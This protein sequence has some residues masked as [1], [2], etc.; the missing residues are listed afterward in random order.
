MSLKVVG[1]RPLTPHVE[2]HLIETGLCLTRPATRGALDNAALERGFDQ[3]TSPVGT[4]WV[5]GSCDNAPEPDDEAWTSFI[6]ALD[7]GPPFRVETA[8]CLRAPSGTLY[9]FELTTWTR[10]LGSAQ[11]GDGQFSYLRDGDV[12]GCE[13]GFHGANCESSCT[14]GV[15]NGEED[16]L[17][18]GEVCGGACGGRLGVQLP[19]RVHDRVDRLR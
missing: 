15:W 2:C 7:R 4:S 16:A 11:P 3:T 5:L 17:D 9:N 14:D 8:M 1:Y 10:G 6:G 13:P 19:R 12:C 18:C